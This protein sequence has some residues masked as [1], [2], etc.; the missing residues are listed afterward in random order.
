M[1]LLAEAFNWFVLAVASLAFA[2]SLG[3]PRGDG[4]D[5]PLVLAGCMALLLAV[6]LALLVFG[7]HPSHVLALRS[8]T[9]SYPIM[10]LMAAAYG[11]MLNGASGICLNIYRRMLKL[12]R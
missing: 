1:S 3:R 10:G 5:V 4:R 8:G 7:Y 2:V 12:F 9:I 6:V 11:L